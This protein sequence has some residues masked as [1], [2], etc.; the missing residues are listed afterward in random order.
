MDEK[1]SIFKN[2]TRGLVIIVNYNQ[3]M[4]VNSFLDKLSLYHPIENSIFVDDGSTDTSKIK[5]EKFQ[6]QVINH[7]FNLGAG[8][9]IRSGIK[10]G[11]DNQ[12][13]YVV[14]MSSNGKM[15]PEELHSIIYPIEKENY[16]WMIEP[17]GEG[18]ME[19]GRKCFP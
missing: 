18:N 6:Y 16:V 19:M 4:E 17:A 9:A 10:Y 12:Y 15:K 5:A 11:I 1:K 2:K 3:D 14:I 13:E 8:A 7:P